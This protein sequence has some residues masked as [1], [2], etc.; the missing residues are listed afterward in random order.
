MLLYSFS[1]FPV[2]FLFPGATCICFCVQDSLPGS[3]SASASRRPS[4]CGSQVPLDGLAAS[5]LT[6]TLSMPWTANPQEMRRCRLTK[7]SQVL[8]KPTATSPSS[9]L[10][11]Q[12]GSTASEPNTHTKVTST[13]NL[14]QCISI[15]KSSP[16]SPFSQVSDKS[17]VFYCEDDGF[18]AGG[19]QM[20]VQGS[21][22]SGKN[23]NDIGWMM[24]MRMGFTVMAGPRYL[25][26]ARES[27][28][29]SSGVTV[30]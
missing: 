26:L 8:G 15:P 13:L 9:A 12:G 21:I 7:L 24:C 28:S 16:A 3:T 17:R 19:S 23:T 4:G 11:E 5:L 29:H 30:T 27:I 2:H 1:F 6:S 18:I 14:M 20:S 10:C 22:Q 25:R